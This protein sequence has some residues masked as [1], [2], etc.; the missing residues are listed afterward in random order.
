MGERGT[1]T[2]RLIVR[3]SG[4]G[5]ILAGYVLIIT[6]NSIYWGEWLGNPD[7]SQAVLALPDYAGLVF[8]A[9]AVIAAL[10][11]SLFLASLREDE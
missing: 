4:F 10:G 9:G 7:H 6:I 1:K 8:L 3:W 11:C 5:C 2:V